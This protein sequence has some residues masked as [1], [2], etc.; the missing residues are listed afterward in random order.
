MCIFLA[1]TPWVSLSWVFTETGSLSSAPVLLIFFSSHTHPLRSQHIAFISTALFFS[2]STFSIKSIFT[3]SHSLW[4]LGKSL[5][6][7]L[8]LLCV[9]HWR[10]LNR[11]TGD[12]G[13]LSHSV[14]TQPF[15]LTDSA[16]PK[17]KPAPSVCRYSR[18]TSLCLWR[19]SCAKLQ[20]CIVC[21][22]AAFMAKLL[23]VLKMSTSLA[24][25]EIWNICL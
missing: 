3:L 13:P 5:C 22:A 12:S 19:L 23:F 8:S 17:G 1:N 11:E 7:D 15:V 20:V 10:C 6:S 14:G 16:L 4:L 25:L 2:H 18:Y 24:T 9:F 21:L